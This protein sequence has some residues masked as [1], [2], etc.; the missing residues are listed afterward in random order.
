MGKAIIII[1]VI[2]CL[3]L[4]VIGF[5]IDFVTGSCWILMTTII[6]LPFIL[7]PR[8]FRDPFDPLLFSFLKTLFIPFVL[9]GLL[10][11]LYP[12]Y[13][14]NP[15]AFAKMLLFTAVGFVF[16]A[17]GLMYKSRQRPRAALY[18]Y[19]TD[20]RK[21][22]SYLFLGIVLYI[23]S[24]L[25]KLYIY[26]LGITHTAS[27]TT[28]N[29]IS[30]NATL[31]SFLDIFYSLGAYSFVCII[32]IILKYRRKLLILIAPLCVSEFGLAIANGSRT[33]MILP[34][35]YVLLVYHL[36]IKKISLKKFAL[37]SLVVLLVLIPI[38]TSFRNNY[39]RFLLTNDNE[40]GYEAIASSF[41]G[42]GS[43]M[44]NT[45]RVESLQRL[46]SPLE[47]F[48]R[49]V[50]MVPHESAY[51]IGGTFF[52]GVLTQF[53][54]RFMWADKPIILPGREFAKTFWKKDLYD[55][56]GTS[57]E[58]SILGEL[59][60]NF[61]II[62]L[63]MMFFVGRLIAFLYSYFLRHK[64][65]EEFFIVRY[66]FLF[67]NLS[68]LMAGGLQTNVA[69]LFK[70]LIV[71][72]IFLIVLTRKFPRKILPNRYLRR[73]TDPIQAQ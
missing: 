66:L 3:I 64:N 67:N 61:W 23:V 31:L 57:E 5:N 11:Y 18:V 71:L 24:S 21:M 56:F 37:F 69:Q 44:E 8:I 39:Q 41:D 12:V 42:G 35:L 30:G 63:I 6:L 52:P 38:T 70:E 59:Y 48:T 58:I 32:Y 9:G 19:T 65:Y 45:S 17:I 2:L 33:Q 28:S 10:M 13:D 43:Q 50:E 25:A 1:L 20:K 16:L 26:F 15:A 68:I 47:G 7:Y 29:A 72:N 4:I 36:T 53:V 60:Y 27:D 54:P 34:L 22:N 46:Y 14:Y 55:F 73:A 40:V 49:V 51:Q 62:G